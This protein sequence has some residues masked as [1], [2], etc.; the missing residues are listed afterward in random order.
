VSDE[1]RKAERRN[2]EMK[3]DCEEM[4]QHV[5]QLSTELQ[6]AREDLDRLSVV[7]HELDTAKQVSIKLHDECERLNAQCQLYRQHVDPDDTLSTQ[8]ARSSFTLKRRLHDTTCC[9]TGCQSR[10]TTGLTTGC[11]VYTAAVVK[12]VV[13]VRSTRLSNR[14]SNQFDNRLDVCFHD[15]AGCHTGCRTDLTTG[16]IV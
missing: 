10:L 7:E 14:L 1:L 15:T 11:I 6:Q 3:L 9:Q 13:A 12:P 16:C 8:L 4:E 2:D 5:S